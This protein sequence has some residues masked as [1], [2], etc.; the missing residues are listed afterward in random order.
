MVARDERLAQDIGLTIQPDRN[1]PDLILVD[2]R[3]TEPLLVF[4]AR[5]LKSVRRCKDHDPL[6]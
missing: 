5:F 4:R 3:P 1:L 2:L 6:R